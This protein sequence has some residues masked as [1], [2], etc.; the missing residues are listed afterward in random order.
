LQGGYEELRLIASRI[1]SEAAS[2][3]RDRFCEPSMA[4]RISGETMRADKISEDYIIEA[5]LKEGLEVTIVS[6]EAG[7][8]GS[9]DLIALIDPLDGSINYVNCIPWAAVSIA[10]GRRLD[11]KDVIVA[12]SVAPIF[13]EPPLSF[14]LGKG[15]YRGGT[16]IREP[17]KRDSEI[18][19]VYVDNKEAADMIARLDSV[20]RDY[21]LRSLGS[22]SL[23]L[24]YVGLG[25]IEAFMDL[26]ARLRN[27][28]VAAAQGIIRECGGY[29]VNSDG[30][31]LMV[32]LK[33][34][35]K[36][37]KIIAT[38]NK[39]LLKIILNSII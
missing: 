1:S 25:L 33:P 26:R 32:P 10:F 4:K 7:I 13:N 19:A 15:C 23:E 5:L 12:G 28:D 35:K 3:L 38:R 11:G 22:A 6:E 9:G 21:K 37:G 31:E 2:L 17:P 30:R 29:I 16:R 20:I 39:K 36:L 18:I 34:I 14:A 24:S 8:R 27:I